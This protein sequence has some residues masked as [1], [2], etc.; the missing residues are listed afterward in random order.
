MEFKPK[1]DFKLTPTELTRIFPVYFKK[2][3]ILIKYFY[4]S[5]TLR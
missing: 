1:N 5:K 4:K 2:V 3:N